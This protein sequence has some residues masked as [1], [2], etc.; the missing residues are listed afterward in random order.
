[1]QQQT[2]AE[3]TFEPYRKSTRRERFLDEIN[4][5]VPWAD[6]VAAM[7]RRSASFA[8][9]WKPTSWARSSLH[10]SGRIWRSTA[11]R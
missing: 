9:Y 8:I 6:L 2:L 10:E 4:R 7:R 11:C 1:M 3:V 5:V